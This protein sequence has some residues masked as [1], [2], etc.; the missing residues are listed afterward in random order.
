MDDAAP[1]FGLDRQIDTLSRDGA[2]LA[3]TVRRDP[4]ARLRSCPDWTGADLLAHVCA[5]ARWVNDLLSGGSAARELPAVTT[6]DADATWDDDLARLVGV[7]RTTPPDAPAP[8]W[9]VSP[10]TVAFWQRRA[11]HELAV[12]RWDAETA[13]D[14][15]PTPI[16]ADV[17]ADGVDEFFDV[18][19][20]TGLAAGMVPSTA[21]TLAVE[22]TDR[23]ARRSVDLPEAGPVTTIRG[24]AEDVL[25]A[26]WGRR[27]L[28]SLHTGGD[29]T[30]LQ[31]W[32]TI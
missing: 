23:G 32:P 2:R 17:A 1:A 11:A 4:A 6:A 31:H 14:A 16:D 22:L 18:F 7:L 28:L 12:H 27:P 25:L 8:N 19:V 29:P 21:A 3:A 24:T 9:A 13:G 26:V 5:F 20:A 30:L 10:D 15:D